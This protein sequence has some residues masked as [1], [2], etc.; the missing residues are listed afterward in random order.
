MNQRDVQH[1]RKINAT[2]EAWRNAAF[3]CWA[4]VP[5]SLFVLFC[6]IVGFRHDYSVVPCLIIALFALATA[7]S[8]FC[9]IRTHVR[10]ILWGDYLKQ[11]L[12]FCDAQ[13]VVEQELYYDQG[14]AALEA[15]EADLRNNENILRLLKTALKRR[16]LHKR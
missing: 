3:V 12:C 8:I 11:F 9:A 6:S 13:T 14:H 4:L 2:V 16:R 5:I 15:L 10:W 7:G 1:L